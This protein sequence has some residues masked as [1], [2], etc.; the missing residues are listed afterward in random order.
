MRADLDVRR[1]D[2]FANGHAPGAVNINVQ[3]EDFVGKVQQAFPDKDA[4]ILV[5]SGTTSARQHQYGS[6]RGTVV[7]GALSAKALINQTNWHR[8]GCRFVL[9]ATVL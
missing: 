7:G 6:I 1:P 8:S 4:K 9:A 3:G 5:V 2:E